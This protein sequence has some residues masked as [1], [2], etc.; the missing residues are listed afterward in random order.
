MKIPGST[1]ALS[2]RGLDNSTQAKDALNATARRQ[3]ITVRRTARAGR[4]YSSVI[5]WSPVGRQ[6]TPPGGT[7]G[8]LRNRE[9]MTPR[10]RPSPRENKTVLV[11]GY[12]REGVTFI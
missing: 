6:Q 8:S 1:A 9:G 11:S 7:S 10:W 4:R 3:P 5:G 2:G 12:C